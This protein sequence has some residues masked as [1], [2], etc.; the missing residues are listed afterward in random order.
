MKRKDEGETSADR[1]RGFAERW[2]RRTR[3]IWH[4]ARLP[5]LLLASTNVPTSFAPVGSE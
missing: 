4:L 5:L 2:N 1:D 3:K